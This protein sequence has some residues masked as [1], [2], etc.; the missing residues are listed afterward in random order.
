[1]NVRPVLVNFWMITLFLAASCGEPSPS[2]K[3]PRQQ[4]SLAQEKDYLSIVISLDTLPSDQ[5]WKTVRREDSLLSLR[6]DSNSNPFFHY[7]RAR[8]LLKQDYPDSAMAQLE[9]MRGER[10][11]SNVSLLREYTILDYNSRNNM[12]VEGELMQKILAAMKKAERLQSPVT[13]RFYDLMAKAYY[14]NENES[15]SL[16][17]AERHFRSHPFNT[18]PVVMQRHYDVSYLL[19]HGMDDFDKMMLYNS[20]ARKLAI[21]T[22]D[23]VAIARTYDSEAMVLDKRGEFAKS[24]A[25]SKIYVDFLERTNRIHEL[26]YNNLATSFNHNRLPDSA[27]KYYHKAMALAKSKANT[28]Q[29]PIYYKG[30]VEAYK[31]KGDMKN[32]VEALDSAYGIEVRNIRKIEAVKFADIHE[33][34]DAE[35]KDRDIADLSSRNALNERIINQQRWTLGLAT[36]VFLGIVGFLYFLYRQVKLNERN[37]L[38][39]S[40]NERLLMEQKLLQVQ[41]NPHFIFNSI[42]NLQSLVAS[43][44]TKES[45]R[46]LSV[47]SGL[48]RNVLEQSRRDFILLNEEIDSLENY[49]QLQQMRYAGLFDYEISVAEGIC[50]G[51]LL[52][53][54][55]LIQ[56]F[57]ENSIEHGFRNISYKGMLTIRFEVKDERLTINVADNGQG[58]IDKRSGVQKKQS[59]AQ[60]ILKER[61]QVLFKSDCQRARFDI[62]NKAGAG[63]RGVTVHIILPVI[64]D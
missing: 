11:D 16:E 57:V 54:P 37:K 32:A 10:A 34:Y 49:L 48:L 39:Q 25:C 30:L 9:K 19:A 63:G 6:P 3:V 17:Y 1:M 23:S 29:T 8:I 41:L 28:K 27:I 24:L 21:H 52:I 61:I 47:F 5:F 15:E 20:L 35:K 56:P 38:L 51:E 7:F 60:A 43:G 31:L 45:V 50:P 33:K 22:G 42:A 12:M 26:A 46:Y 4:E 44:D 36:M 62:E 59:L 64:K 18:H 14:Q 13:Y 2:R 53:P 58:I 55:M 40:E